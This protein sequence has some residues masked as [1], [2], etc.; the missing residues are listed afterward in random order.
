MVADSAWVG[1]QRTHGAD[2]AGRLFQKVND[3]IDRETSGHKRL[4]LFYLVDAIVQHSSKER[5]AARD[6]FAA[7]TEYFLSKMVSATVHGGADNRKATLKVLQGWEKHAHLPVDV[8][9]PLVGRLQ[10]QVTHMRGAREA[11]TKRRQSESTR[12]LNL[13]SRKCVVRDKSAMRE[14]HRSGVERF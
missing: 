5:A 13:I 4:T 10:Q 11:K 8:L 12:Q 6:A 3:K 14:E 9:G 1:L 2:V 7:S